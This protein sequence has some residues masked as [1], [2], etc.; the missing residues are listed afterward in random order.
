MGRKKQKGVNKT[1]GVKST[2]HQHMLKLAGWTLWK[3]LATL[4]NHQAGRDLEPLFVLENLNF[5]LTHTTD[6]VLVSGNAGPQS[7]FSHMAQRQ[8]GWQ[9]EEETDP[10]SFGSPSRL[11]YIQRY[12][13]PTAT[14][15]LH[16]SMLT[17]CHW[18]SR[19]PTNISSDLLDHVKS[20]TAVLTAVPRVCGV[21]IQVLKLRLGRKDE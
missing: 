11:S 4:L 2:L 12:S 21:S 16:G 5:L 18:P 7:N 9:G 3:G 17:V 19:P 20:I 1:D 6:Q 14:D 8:T 15:E 10:S 13:S